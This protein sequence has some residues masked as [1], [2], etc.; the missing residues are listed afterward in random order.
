MA[1]RKK[2]KIP[3]Q[4][5]S[6]PKVAEPKPAGKKIKY[7]P[8]SD[9][10]K[11]QFP[12]RICFLAIVILSFLMSFHTLT[13]TDIFW[14]LKTGEIIFSTRQIPR[15]DLYSFTAAGK[16]WIDSQWLFQLIIYLLYRIGGYAG[17]ILFGSGLTA[18]TWLLALKTAFNR[19]KYFSIS[20][21][22]L[23][24][25]LTA[26]TRLKL[27]PE[28]LTFFL[29]TLEIYLLVLHQQGKK[30]ALYPLP[31]LLLLWVNSEGLWPIYFVI[32]S[33]FLGE[34]ILGLP[35][36]K[37]G[38]YLPSSLSVSSNSSVLRLALG[39]ACSIPVAF[40]NPHGLRG[41]IFPAILLREVSQ[42]G[43]IIGQSIADLQSPFVIFS[44]FD[45]ASYIALM[46]FS[47]LTVLLSILRRK[48][49]PATFLLWA[50]FLYLSLTAA[51][52][53]A[54]FALITASLMGRII[55][56]SQS[57]DGFPFPGRARRLIKFRPW[58]TALLLLFM[59]GLVFDLA[60][61]RF[62]LR[63]LSYSRF[64]IGALETTYPIR[65]AQFLKSC[66]Q[67]LGGRVSLRIFPD[68]GSAGYL[69]WAGYPE[70]KVYADPRLEVYGEQL[71]QAHI[72]ALADY[73]DFQQEDKRYD[74]DLVMLT[75]LLAEGSLI[76]NLQDDPN[77]VLIYFDGLNVV[78]LKNQPRF[79]PLVEKYR[80]DFKTGYSSPLPRDERGPWLARERLTRGYIL[81]SLGR[82]ELARSEF[83]QGVQLTPGD[84]NL[85]FYLG[86]TLNMLSRYQEAKPYL[87]KVAKERPDS[88]LNQFQLARAD[89]VTGQPDRAIEIFERILEKNPQQITACIDL[90]KVY[91]LTASPR[92]HQQWQTCWQIY[93]T[94][95]R[96]FQDQAA[97][98]SRFLNRPGK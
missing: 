82:L 24:C 27:R 35:Q 6:P 95:P 84:L 40:L 5:S 30:F 8:D 93:Q 23:I 75:P 11:D 20:L 36:L 63:N 4:L 56:E 90:A 55:A 31:A 10:A 52:N 38:A 87:E 26:S 46:A 19:Q 91:E 9:R 96:Q 3:H 37:L 78:F 92:A 39:L 67:E 15:A 42:P 69:I 45:Q 58:A 83:A 32:F 61:S 73:Q 74:F 7:A 64:G 62:F 72:S 76:K 57:P 33:A 86:W 51:R 65:A 43:S 79:L 54:L 70:W 49:Y 48:I 28:V 60:G 21:L 80:I 53:A 88:I 25:L 47:S 66:C 13:D 68:P 29:L 41:V 81:F 34:Q 12:A 71:I 94:D 1:R 22:V 97:E 50:G 89:A 17:M 98:I 16:E 44:G 59:S 85:N 2:N 18:L 77:W 14:H